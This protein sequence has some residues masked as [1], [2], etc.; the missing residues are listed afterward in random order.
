MSKTITGFSTDLQ[1]CAMKT[2]LLKGASRLNSLRP[3]PGKAPAK[4]AFPV[5]EGLL[6]RKPADILYLQAEGNYTSIWFKDGSRTLLSQNLRHT[7]RLL[8]GRAEF[9]RVHRSHTVNLTCL[10]R[11]VRG[12]NAYVVLDNGQEIPVAQARRSEFWQTLR[13]YFSV[14]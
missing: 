9:V 4:V 5:M 1:T 10:E 12:R 3:V 8:H 6:F 7:E 13:D 2:I 11:Y 14:E